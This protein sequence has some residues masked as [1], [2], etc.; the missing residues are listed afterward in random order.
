M[1]KKIPVEQTI[2]QC[3]DL[4]E[5]QKLVKLSDKYSHVEHEHCIPVQRVEGVRVKHTYY[6]YPKTQ[7][8]TYKSYR[9]F[10]SN[11]LQDGRILKCGGSRGKP[12]KFADTPDHCFIY[13]DDVNG[14]KVPQ[15]L[16]KQW[17]IDLAKRRLKQFGIAA[18]YRKGGDDG[19]CS[20][21]KSAN[22]E[23]IQSIK[24]KRL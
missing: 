20:N 18:Q 23:Q 6:D 13:N 1:V 3:D 19:K 2:N 14:V 5:F 17:Y 10:A 16:D 11:E 4:K 7:R 9:V 24:E 8:Y 21:D 22:V 12:E 15:N